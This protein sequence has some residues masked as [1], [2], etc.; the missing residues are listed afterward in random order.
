MDTLSCRGQIQLDMWEWVKDEITI[1]AT[2]GVY[3]SVNP[4][5]SH[6]AEKGFW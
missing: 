4:F 3:G 5:Q 1:A 2:E 6:E